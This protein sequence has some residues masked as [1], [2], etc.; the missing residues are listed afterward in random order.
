VRRH[1]LYVAAVLMALFISMGQDV[2]WAQSAS[3]AQ[4]KFEVA[5]VK[6]CKDPDQPPP[7]TSSPG[8]LSL[9]CWPLWRLIADAYDT[10]ATGTVDPSKLLVPLPLDGAPAWVNSARY[11]IDAK[12]EGPQSGAMMR[13]PMMQALLEERFQLKTHRETREIAVDIMTVAKSGPKL[14]PTEEGSCTHLDPTDLAQSPKPA[15]GKP[16]CLIPTTLSRGPITVFDVQGITLDAFAKILHPNRRPVINRTGLTGAFDIHLEWE[17]DVQES[18]A[19]D[20]GAASLPS[21][22]MSAIA[23]TRE[24]LG[25]RLDPGKGPREFLIIDHVERPSGN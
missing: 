11:T 8:R 7:S 3:P 25:L 15:G 22:H 9:G 18:P 4:P 17:P 20:D 14:H 13:G 6:E 16:W 5:S 24:Q 10:F 23:A 21:P 12:T 2:T 19:P 1:L